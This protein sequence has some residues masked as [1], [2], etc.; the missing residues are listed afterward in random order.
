MISLSKLYGA[1]DERFPFARA[2]S[3]DKV[4]LLVG[5]KSA[6]VSRALV[7]YEVT[8]AALDLA[9]ERGCDVVVAYHPLIFRPLEKLDFS[10]RTARLCA[11]LIRAEQNLIC[12]HTALDGATPPHALGDALARQLGIEG[13]RVHKASGTQKL[14]QL[15]YFVP[16]SHLEK[17]REAAWQQGAGAIGHYD[18]ASFALQGSGT[19]RP[20][21]GA[22]PAEGNVGTRAETNEWRVELLVPAES[23]GRVLEAIKAAHPYEEVAYYM[24]ALQNSDDNQ[25]YGPLRLA[26]VPDAT[27]FEWV[28]R[29][30]TQ[31]KIPSVRVA[32]AEEGTSYTKVACSPGSGASFISSLPHGTIFISGDFKHHDALAAQARGVA[33]ID[34][35][36]A[37]TETMTV[38][39]MAEAIEDCVEVVRATPR[40]PF[41]FL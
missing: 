24:T 2:E 16:E 37:A 22:T 41:D 34:V 8:E 18:E 10:D 33:L 31:L 1:L 38:D 40:N 15:V 13:A 9:Q 25:Q 20:L 12:V 4:G 30:K 19:F 17:T 11:R 26:S 32:M 5:D 36:H 28:E 27:L 23:A 7:C 29:A 39:M 3:W 35:T 21:E 14:V 6:S